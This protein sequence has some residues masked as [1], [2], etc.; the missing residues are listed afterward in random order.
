MLKGYGKKHNVLRSLAIQ[1]LTCQQ[2]ANSLYS[3]N[4]GGGNERGKDWQNN[5]FANA[6]RFLVH[7]FAV[8]ALLGRETA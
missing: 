4:D 7:F 6:A 3:N 1:T 8:V 2:G 5:N